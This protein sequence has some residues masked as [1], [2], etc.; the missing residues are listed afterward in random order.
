MDK[1]KRKG[2]R[3]KWDLVLKFEVVAN[4]EAEATGI[5]ATELYK[6]IKKRGLGDIIDFDFLEESDE[7]TNS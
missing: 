3:M 6:M 7:D 5:L 4:S 1:F 2:I